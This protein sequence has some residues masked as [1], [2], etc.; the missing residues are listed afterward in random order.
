MISYLRWSKMVVIAISGTARRTSFFWNREERCEGPGDQRSCRRSRQRGPRHHNAATAKRLNYATC[1]DSCSGEIDNSW[2]S[3]EI[4]RA[5]I[6]SHS[7]RSE[8]QENL[9]AVIGEHEN[10]PEGGFA[11]ME[12]PSWP[13][14]AEV[15]PDPR[16]DAI[17]EQELSTIFLLFFSW[18]CV[19]SWSKCFLDFIIFFVFS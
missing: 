19:V 9:R 16:Q 11:E 17:R 12:A 4:I 7:Q 13:S 18:F 14:V 5:R 6:L 15:S 3:G 1:R 8:I 2:P 10:E